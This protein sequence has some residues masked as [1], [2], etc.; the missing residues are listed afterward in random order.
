[1]LSRL[2]S[3]VMG[4][5]IG[6]LLGTA[7]FPAPVKAQSGAA[8]YLPT[9]RY[10]DPF[11]FCTEGVPEHGWIAVNPIAG[12]WTAINYYVNYQWIPTYTIV[13]PRGMKYGIWSGPGPANM[14]PFMH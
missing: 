6:A 7:L 1:M 8:I 12:T 9:G 5:V 10:N 3:L 14:S 11:V 13:C 4:L 2:P